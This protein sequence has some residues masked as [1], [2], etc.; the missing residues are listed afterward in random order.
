MSLPLFNGTG[1]PQKLS[2]YP[3]RSKIVG[4]MKWAKE[5]EKH[6]HLDLTVYWQAHS[7]P[8]ALEVMLAHT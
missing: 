7:N 3:I 5:N 6:R 4:K 2:L 8:G 1:L